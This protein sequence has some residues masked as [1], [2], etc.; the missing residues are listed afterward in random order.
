MHR[1]EFLAVGVALLVLL[2]GACASDS[3]ASRDRATPS[4]VKGLPAGDDATVVRIVD[5][6]T[7]VVRLLDGTKGH[8]ATVRLIGIDTPETKDPRTSVQCFGRE[9]SAR[10]TQLLPVGTPVRLAY[11]VERNDRYG[12]ILAYVHRA[13]R[14]LFVNAALVRDGYA[15][16]ATYPPNVAHAEQFV[17]LQRAA[18]DAGR[19]L[20]AECPVTEDP[21]PEPTVV[22]HSGGAACDPAYPDACIPPSPPD[23]DCGDVSARS[24]PVLAPDPHRFDSNGDGVG[25]EGPP[26]G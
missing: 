2:A 13:D 5:G 3:T 17:A 16:V 8:D 21:A 9:A 1:R 19:G 14:G 7:I 12:R 4:T 20:W 22:A 11:D 25:C 10:T 26:T 24:F 18:R 6:D 23:L 15:S